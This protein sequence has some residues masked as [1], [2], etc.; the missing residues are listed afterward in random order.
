MREEIKRFFNDLRFKEVLAKYKN[1]KLPESAFYERLLIGTLKKLE[2]ITVSDRFDNEPGAYI[3][4]ADRL[5]Q[6]ITFAKA[7]IEEK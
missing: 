3:H 5:L 2:E 7:K 4:V 1:D 6:I